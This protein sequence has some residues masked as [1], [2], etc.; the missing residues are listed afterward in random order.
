VE[1]RKGKEDG[2]IFEH[3]AVIN[4]MMILR[5]RAISRVAGVQEM[6]TS[7]HPGVQKEK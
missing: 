5:E 4:I 7:P 6:R 2:T 3:D 1:T